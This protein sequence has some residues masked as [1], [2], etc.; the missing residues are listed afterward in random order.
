MTGADFSYLGDI[1]FSAFRAYALT[2]RNR[3]LAF[4]VFILVASFLIPDIV[5][6]RDICA[7]TPKSDTMAV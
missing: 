2:D 5:S 7:A 6:H 3:C 1:V 4:V